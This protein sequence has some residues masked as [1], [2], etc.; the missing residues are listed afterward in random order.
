MT[1]YIIGEF[2]I[3]GNLQINED[4]VVKDWL[5]RPHLWWIEQWVDYKTDLKKF[6]LIRYRQINSACTDLK[7]SIDNETTK[8]LIDRL[9]L[10]ELESGVFRYASEWCLPIR[11]TIIR[12]YNRNKNKRLYSI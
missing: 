2:K 4:E 3:A 8:R 11:Y 7:V 9:S 10:K 6:R 1:K 12:E 5:K